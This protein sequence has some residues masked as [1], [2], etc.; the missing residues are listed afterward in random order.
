MDAPE[1]TDLQI[2]YLCRELALLLH[3][4]IPEA[5]GLFLMAEQTDDG[6]VRP[7]LEAMAR[8]VAGGCALSEAVRQA[9][10]FPAYMSG[11]PAGRKRP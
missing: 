8:Q 10:C 3:T 9:G 4:G 11:P 7:L 5:D 1:M 2:A 6:P